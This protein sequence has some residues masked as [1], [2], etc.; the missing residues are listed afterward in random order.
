MKNRRVSWF[1]GR[2]LRWSAKALRPTTVAVYRH[3][4]RRFVSDNGD[5]TFA[6]LSPAVLSAWATTWHQSQAMKRLFNWARDDARL[7]RVNPFERAKHPPKGQRRRILTRRETA[8]VLRGCRADLRALLLAYRETIARPGELRAA[9]WVDIS[10]NETRAEMRRALLA[11]KACIV[12]TEYKSRKRRRLPNAPRVILLS[13][14]VGRLLAR[15]LKRK[16]HPHQRIFQTL[17]GR[18]WT[19][20][21]LRCR[22]RRLRRALCLTRD[23]RGENIVPYSFRHTGATLATSFGVRDRTLADLLGHTETATT[24]RYQHL[25]AD[26]LCAA[27]QEIWNPRRRRR[28]KPN[29]DRGDTARN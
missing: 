20:N 12:L 23:R 14:R 28:R 19:A 3:Y 7:I 2:F 22:M 29:G 27:M 26:H 15:L 25:Q 17:L 18:P 10:P 6:R 24:A 11:G 8:Q 1:A 21:A 13:P 4:F 5:L 16:P 9:A